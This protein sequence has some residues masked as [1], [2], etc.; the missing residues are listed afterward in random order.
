MY[1]KFHSDV[2]TLS[3]P[4]SLAFKIT[5]LD[6]NINSTWALKYYNSSGLQTAINITGIGDNQWKTTNV[7]IQNP[8]ITQNGVLGSDFMLVNTD[9]ID[10]IFHGIELDITRT[11]TLSFIDYNSENSETLIF[12]NP[13]SSI[14]YWN[15]NIVSDEI[16]I[17]NSK[18]QV[19]SNVNKPENNSLSIIN[20]EKGIYFIVFLKDKKRVLT[21]KVIKD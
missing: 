17:Y 20:L 8:I 21:Y 11:G 16:I 19:V 10:D 13:T 15:K 9:N 18:G 14:L 7:T 3:D 2:F 12:P 4:A 5:W 1:F 6:K